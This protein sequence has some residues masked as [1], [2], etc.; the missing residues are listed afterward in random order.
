MQE[1]TYS[2]NIYKI[3]RRKIVYIYKQNRQLKKL[4]SKSKKIYTYWWSKCI[5]IVERKKVLAT[6]IY[7]FIVNIYS[8]KNNCIRH[9]ECTW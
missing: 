4:N 3:Y 7:S 5:Q 2:D 1:Y 6:N 8:F 9:K